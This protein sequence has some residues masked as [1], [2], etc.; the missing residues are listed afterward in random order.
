[1]AYPKVVSDHQPSSIY[2]FILPSLGIRHFIYD[3]DTEMAAQCENF[4][5][6]EKELEHLL[7]KIVRGKTDSR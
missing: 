4:E 6:V 3:D 2:T 5:V 1:M 7:Q